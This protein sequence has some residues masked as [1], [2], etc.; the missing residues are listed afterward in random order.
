MSGISDPLNRSSYGCRPCP[1]PEGCHTVQCLD[2]LS[3]C[4]P[5]QCCPARRLRFYPPE[6]PSLWQYPRAR[7][8]SERG[9]L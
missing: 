8:G 9:S 3:R 4:G 6:P 5:T 1:T 7:P 2:R